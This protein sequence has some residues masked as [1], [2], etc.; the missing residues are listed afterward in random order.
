MNRGTCL[1]MCK[2]SQNDACMDACMCT[3]RMCGMYV[4]I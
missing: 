4:G 2:K 3:V 1:D